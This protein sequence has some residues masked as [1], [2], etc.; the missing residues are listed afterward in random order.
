MPAETSTFIKL[1]VQSILLNSIPSRVSNR[2]PPISSLREISRLFVRNREVL[3]R[4]LL[5]LAAD[6]IRDLL[7]LGLLQGVL[8]V[9]R[10]LLE[11]VLLDPVDACEGG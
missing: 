6:G 4:R 10:A 1:E 7:I 5:I 2:S 11:D 9:L 8:V 3:A